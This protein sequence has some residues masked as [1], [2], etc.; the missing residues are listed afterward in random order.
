MRRTRPAG[1]GIG[2]A[3]GSV[4]YGDSGGNPFHL[5]QLARSTERAGRPT[6]AGLGAALGLDVP[7]AVA[8]ALAEEPAR[9]SQ[10]S[11]MVA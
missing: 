5:E 4:M 9:L 2:A 10:P 7:P 11:Q 1:A 8:A 3:T 6:A